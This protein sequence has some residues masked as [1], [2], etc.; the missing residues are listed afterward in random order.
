[1][2]H[3]EI[4][5][6]DNSGS[7]VGTIATECASPKQAAILAHALKFRESLQVEVWHDDRLAYV[8]PAMFGTS[9]S[10]PFPR[11]FTLFEQ[12]RLRSIG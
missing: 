10:T 5:Y 7:L 6:V 12:P 9:F 3:F 11:P 2:P 1:M 8:R 4:C